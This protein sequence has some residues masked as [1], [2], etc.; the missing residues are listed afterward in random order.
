MDN[1]GRVVTGVAYR[2]PEIDPRLN[3]LPDNHPQKLLDRHWHAAAIKNN[4]PPTER[5][6]FV[7]RVMGDVARFRQ[8]PWAFGGA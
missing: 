1:T 6:K 5:V 2:A 4:L 3:F 8:I 7:R